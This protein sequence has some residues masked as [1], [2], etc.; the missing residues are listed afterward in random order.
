MEPLIKHTKYVDPM[1]DVAFKQLLGQEKNKHLT[2]GLLEHVFNLDIEELSFVNVEH[3]GDTLEDRNAVFD[4]QCRSKQIGEFIVEMQVREQRHFSKR[5]LYYS[6]FPI[7]AQAP[8]GDWN[9]DF[10]PVFFL[11]MLNFKIANTEDCIH[12]YSIREESTGHQL[13]DALQFVFMEVGPFN[14]AWEDCKSFEE[15]FLYYFKNLPTFASKPDT[16]QDSYFEE[17]LAAAEYSNMTKAER[18][19]Y[20]RRLKIRRD[21]FAADE[22]AREKAEELAREKAEELAREKAEE[23]A[24]ELVEKLAREMAEKEREKAT[25]E[26]QIQIARNLLAMGLSVEQVAQ[27]T[28]LTVEEV[29]KSK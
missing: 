12:R 10:K 9:Y 22:F 19:A 27:G 20:N 25:K 1:I 2:K 5:A 3:P 14:K 26:S 28:G 21:N 8:K 7:T 16:Q 18:E 24:R 11:G 6:T 17:L 15:K 23:L 13:T 29:A 4:I